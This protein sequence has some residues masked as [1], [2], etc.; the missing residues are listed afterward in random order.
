MAEEKRKP[1][2]ERLR[3]YTDAA[4]KA[5]ELDLYSP[6]P[7]YDELEISR[8]GSGLSFLAEQFGEDDP[9]VTKVLAGKSPSE[10]AADLVHGTKLKDV[11][12]RKKIAE[13]GTEAIATSTDPMIQLL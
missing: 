11:A 9:L 13:G 10:R 6:A 7:I 3:E 5:R 12:V 4:I 2:A 8:I 1:N